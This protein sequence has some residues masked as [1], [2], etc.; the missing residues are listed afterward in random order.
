M[1]FQWISPNI[2]FEKLHL[3]GT[4]TS[5][6]AFAVNMVSQSIHSPYEEH[7]DVVYKILRYLKSTPRKRL[8][9]KKNEKREVEVYTNANWTGSITN[10]RSASG[11]ARFFGKILSL[12]GARNKVQLLK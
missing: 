11:I 9:F 10:R 12:G 2:G 3:L 1:G 8:F 5:C 7:L 4:Y 6:Y